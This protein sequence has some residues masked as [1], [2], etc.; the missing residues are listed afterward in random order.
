MTAWALLMPKVLAAS[1]KPM[2]AMQALFTA[3]HVAGL[4]TWGEHLGFLGF[5]AAFLA[6][7]ALELADIT[8]GKVP[9][10]GLRMQASPK[11]PPDVCAIGQGL[12]GPRGGARP[13]GGRL[14]LLPENLLADLARIVARCSSR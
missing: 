8:E 1:L 6:A 5:F 4:I 14:R 2:P 11:F 9:Q 7:A 3:S 12:P 13:G 10:W